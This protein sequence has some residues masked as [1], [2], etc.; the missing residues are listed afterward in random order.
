MWT[1]RPKWA[2]TTTGRAVGRGAGARPLHQTGERGSGGDR[3]RPHPRRRQDPPELGVGSAALGRPCGC[4]G[5]HPSGDDRRGRRGPRGVGGG[6]PQTSPRARGGRTRGGHGRRAGGPPRPIPSS[7]W[8][9]R[10]S[11]VRGPVGGLGRCH[12]APTKAPTLPRPRPAPGSRCLPPGGHSSLL[13]LQSKHFLGSPGPKRPA[14]SRGHALQGQ[15]RV[16]QA[17]VAVALQRHRSRLSWRD[18]VFR[19]RGRVVGL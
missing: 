5:R 7:A 1:R 13:I 19:Q 15:A 14:T 3:Q 4:G 8:S 17:A 18:L 11:A 16:C 6:V 2:P 10:R 12:V 9:R